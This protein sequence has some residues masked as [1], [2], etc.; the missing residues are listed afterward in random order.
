MGDITQQ[1]IV[2][3][4]VRELTTPVADVITS[5]TLVAGV[6]SCNPWNCTTWEI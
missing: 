4:A 3:T 1:R 5:R 2:K 6:I